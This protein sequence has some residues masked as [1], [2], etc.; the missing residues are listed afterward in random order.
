MF[1]EAGKDGAR[2]KIHCDGNLK[3]KPEPTLLVNN[4]GRRIIIRA[5]VEQKLSS[6]TVVH[7][8]AIMPCGIMGQ[9]VL[10]TARFPGGLHGVWQ[11]TERR[12]TKALAWEILEIQVNSLLHFIKI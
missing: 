2:A 8:I 10:G 1:Q 6:E 9:V 5:K 4:F 7:N 12:S 3:T 11:P